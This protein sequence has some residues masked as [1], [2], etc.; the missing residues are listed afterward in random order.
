MAEQSLEKAFKVNPVYVELGKALVMQLGAAY[1]A[2]NPAVGLGMA[3]AK[4]LFELQS[5][6]GHQKDVLAMAQ[7]EGW[8]PDDPRWDAALAEQQARWDTEVRRR[9][10]LRER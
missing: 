8:T 1:A 6:V 4:A 9:D 10:E 7:I 5:A 3:A 2:I